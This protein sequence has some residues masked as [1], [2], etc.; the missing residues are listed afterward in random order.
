MAGQRAVEVEGGIDPPRVHRA[1]GAK[2]EQRDGGIDSVGLGVLA[3]VGGVHAVDRDKPRPV[4]VVG[5]VGKRS[6]RAGD[7]DPAVERRGG[8]QREQR[9]GHVAAAGPPGAVRERGGQ[10][11]RELARHDYGAPSGSRSRKAPKGAA[12][13]PGASSAAMVASSSSVCS[14]S[15]ATPTAA[16]ATPSGGSAAGVA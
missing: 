10:D 9:R 3:A 6:S 4:L 11:R 14:S 12:A 5:E 16:A 7:R 8:Q 13:A 2:R 1:R 15:P